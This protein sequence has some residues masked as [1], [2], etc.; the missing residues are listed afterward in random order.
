MGSDTPVGNEDIKIKGNI[1]VYIFGKINN[2]TNCDENDATINYK[3]INQLFPNRDI[4]KNS[5][6]FI[7][8]DINNKYM[9][10]YR[11]NKKFKK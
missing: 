5:F 9:Y 8:N 6:I 7:N 10:E 11:I 1:N 4:N 2:Q 3:I